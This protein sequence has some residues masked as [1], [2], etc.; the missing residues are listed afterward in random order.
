M[1]IISRDQIMVLCGRQSGRLCGFI[2]PI[3]S[4]YEVVQAT[5]SRSG[6]Y[7]KSVFFEGKFIHKGRV[8]F[9]VINGHMLP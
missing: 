9:R 2:V 1:Y 3:Q 6:G 7:M 4:V 8:V 5:F